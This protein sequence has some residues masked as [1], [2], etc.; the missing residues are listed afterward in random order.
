MMIVTG[1]GTLLV[2]FA[3]KF[4]LRR[5]KSKYYFAFD[6]V[7]I[8]YMLIHAIGTVCVYKEWVPHSFL[9]YP[10]DVM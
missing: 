6:I 4:I 1:V 2:A 5:G 8:V 7:P 10:K 3:I 9:E